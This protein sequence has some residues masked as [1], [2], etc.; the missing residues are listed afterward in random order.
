MNNILIKVL[1]KEHGRKV[2]EFF[3]SKGFSTKYLKGTNVT[4]V[5]CYYGVIDNIF[6]T[7]T[8]VPDNCNV[9]L[10][11]EDLPIPRMVLVKDKND[12][13]WYKRTL[14]ADFSKLNVENPYTCT[15]PDNKSICNWDCMKEIPKPEEMTLEEVCKELGREIKI[16]K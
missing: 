7:S 10:L 3:K 13:G 8:R 15:T 11:P 14:I 12:I 16:I 9:M 1:N 6:C 5:G 2:I 4:N